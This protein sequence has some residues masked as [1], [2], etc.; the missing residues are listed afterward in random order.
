MSA[1]ANLS[2]EKGVKLPKQWPHWARGMRLRQE[3]GRGLSRWFYMVGRGRRWR[4]N[5]DGEFQIGDGD[6]DRWANSMAASIAMP[7]TEAQFRFAVR[8]LKEVT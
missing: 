4:V 3:H 8:Y 1:D 7:R 2:K 6:F 5:N